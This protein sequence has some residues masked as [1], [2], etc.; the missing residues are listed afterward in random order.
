[1][2]A[3]PIVR[4]VAGD[5]PADRLG[6]CYPHEHVFG[7]PPAGMA[8]TDFRLDDEAAAL[9]EVGWFR[10]A[11]GRALVDMSTPDYQR[12]AA[13]LRRVSD[14]TGVHIVCATGFNKDTFSRP[15][16]DP[17]S[18]DELV[19]LY[20]RE[21]TAGI[22]GTDVR[23]GVIKAAT[24]LHA[25]SDCGEKMLRAAARAQAITGAP[26]STHTEAGTMALEQVAL[27]REEG[28]DPRRVII[29]H[30]DRKL[31]MDYL[32]EVAATGA[33]L[34]IDQI[35][36]EKYYPDRARIDAILALAS[37]GFGGQLL[38]SGD[39]ARRSYWPAYGGGPGFTYILW[40]FVPWLREAG[41]S[42]ALI[43]DLLVHNPARALG[44]I[45]L[46]T[47]ESAGT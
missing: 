14:A 10:E 17:R 38:L 16:V 41:A 11:G 5:I 35:S 47:P 42:E 7:A 45:P 28:A 6:V 18:V 37:E 15:W 44:F 22:D 34:G 40:R 9:R 30:M 25:V 20:V 39:L 1:M 24:T 4:T 27:L 13:G 19:A 21:V 31:E 29:G 43:R 3:H 23:A 8:A 2:P 36:K 33:F 26:I 12:D 46:S 32:R